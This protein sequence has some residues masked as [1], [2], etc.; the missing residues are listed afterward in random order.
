MSRT[1]AGAALCVSLLASSAAISQNPPL[2]PATV[3]SVDT[4]QGKITLD[5]GKIP[6]LEMDAMTMA[7]RVQNTSMLKGLR[8]GDK[9][10]FSAE[11]VNG[12]IVVTRL[13]KSN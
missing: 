11:K 8:K 6:N 12:Q 3:D 1:I 9:V 7:F 2:V 4:R 10:Q 13:Q 5:H